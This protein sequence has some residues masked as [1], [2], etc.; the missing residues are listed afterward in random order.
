MEQIQMVEISLTEEE[1]EAATTV[2]RS[3]AL[4]QGPE[5]D[6]FEE[7]FAAKVGA[8]YAVTSSSGTAALHLAYM[9]FLEPGEE[10]LVPSLTFFSTASSVVAAGGKPV[11]C[12]LNPETLTIDL[13]DAERKTTK[14]TRAISPVHLYG[15]PCPV[16]SVRSFAEK[17]GLRV[18][19]D[20]AQ[21][22][23]AAYDGRDV[24]SFEDFVCYSFYPSKNMFVGEGGI[25][26][27]QDK[28]LYT[29]MRYMRSHGETEKYVHTMMG[30]NY[31]MTDVEA[32][33]GRKQLRRLNTMLDAR[34]KNAAALTAGFRPVNGIRTQALEEHALH[35]YH[36]YGIL[37]DE[38]R[39]GISRD[40]L[41]QRLS[42]A[43]IANG[44]VYPRGLHE[45]PVFQEMLG[46]QEL[47]A[48]EAATR[49]VL[50]VPVHHGLSEQDV[51]RIVKSVR[52]APRMD[53]TA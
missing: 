7:E 31:R 28:E 34:R 5:C 13:E 41:S 47:P 37:V 4:R 44:V 33:I 21:A 19:W 36:Q 40:T 50:C 22:H 18:V 6:A 51:E 43:G 2:L 16:P 35:A 32:A 15:N 49:Q 39:F 14:K 27:T 30:L 3:G 45:Q 11:F 9:S 46:K 10:V 1:V 24:G 23:G 25:T 17:H 42:A 53:K 12:D 8:K 29:R 52:E 20:A 38:A 26:T 48:T